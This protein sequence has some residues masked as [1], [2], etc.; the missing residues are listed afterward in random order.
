MPRKGPR[1]WSSSG[2]AA[3]TESSIS[4]ARPDAR[5]ADGRLWRRLWRRARR[6]RA[7]GR[8]TCH[9]RCRLAFRHLSRCGRGE[10]PAPRVETRIVSWRRRVVKWMTCSGVVATAPRALSPARARRS[11]ALPAFPR[12]APRTMSA[13]ASARLALAAPRARR[14]PA[15]RRAPPRAPW[16]ARSSAPPR[17]P[18]RS[19]SPPRARTR[20]RPPRPPPPPPPGPPPGTRCASSRARTRA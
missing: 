14:L 3:T 17:A 8:S 15:P 4:F 13:A 19:P 20:T 9:P 7:L 12:E 1:T 16:V 6:R 10:R 5:Y 11:P 2:I 18:G